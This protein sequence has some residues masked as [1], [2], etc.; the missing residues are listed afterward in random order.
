[1]TEHACTQAHIFV[2]TYVKCGYLIVPTHIAFLWR[3]NELICIKCLLFNGVLIRLINII[4]FNPY[5]TLWG[6]LILSSFSCCTNWLSEML[7]LWLK[8]K[9]KWLGVGAEGGQTSQSER[10]ATLNIHWK[11]WCWSSNTLATWSQEP[12]HWRRP[13]CWETLKAKG[14]EGGREWEW[15]DRSTD[16]MDINLSK[17]R[18]IVE[19][20]GA[21]HATVHEVTVGH[22]F[23]TEQQQQIMAILTPKRRPHESSSF[24]ISTFT[25]G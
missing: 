7:S 23:E 22:G 4:S 3:L 1:M 13:G 21:W 8:V 25:P 11:G 16:S 12:I 2:S 10:K 14:K 15:L 9:G 24:R 17:P 20:G 6:I 18:E 19:G 5:M